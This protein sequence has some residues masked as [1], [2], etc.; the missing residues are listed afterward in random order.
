MD[1]ADT[2]AHDDGKILIHEDNRNYRQH[3]QHNLDLIGY[4]I[5]EGGMGRSVLADNSGAII[6]GNGTLRM[7]NQRGIPQRIIHTDGS[8]LIVVVRDDLAPD[9]PRRQLLA[10]MDNSTTDTSTFDYDLMQQD[11]SVDQLEEMGVE[12]P[13]VELDFH[14][15]AEGNTEEDLPGNTYSDK[16]EGLIYEPTGEDVPV[17]ECYD[18][19]KAKALIKEI[20]AAKLPK[21]IEDFLIHAA[22]R[23]IVFDYR[24]IAEYYANAPANIQDLM[25]KSA[26]VIIDFDKAIKYGFTKL[27]NEIDAMADEDYQAELAKKAGENA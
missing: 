15:E 4:S 5:D 11:F 3:S 25:E 8:E 21:E 9:D 19:T 2:H 6:G 16:V 7:A 12:I 26:L 14:D 22:G 13:E 17:S 10:V 18:I 23:H 27:A 1:N 20:K 24:N